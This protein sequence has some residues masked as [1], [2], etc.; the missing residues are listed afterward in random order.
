MGCVF[1]RETPRLKLNN[2]YISFIQQVPGHHVQVD[3]K[4][5]KLINP[6]I[7]TIKKFQYTAIDDAT[8]IRVLMVY[9]KHNMQTAIALADHVIR[10]V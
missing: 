6:S 4:F 5:L 7:K 10:S 8:R 1:C 2:H 9:G 3:V